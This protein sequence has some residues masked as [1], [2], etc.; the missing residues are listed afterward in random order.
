[1]KAEE[2]RAAGILTVNGGSSSLRLAVFAADG[3]ALVADARLAP[4]PPTDPAVLERFLREAG[5]GRLVAVVHRVVHGGSRLRETCWLDAGVEAEIARL[6]ALA[7]LH[8]GMALDWI[9]AARRACDAPQAA[10]F[11]TAFFVDLPP[12][13]A[14]YALPSELS[15]RFGLRRFGFHGLAHRSMLESWRGL[16]R[17]P[18]AGERVISIQLGSGCSMAAIRDG[19]PVE[20][21]MGYSPLEGLMMATRSGDVDPTVILRLVGEGGFSLEELEGI[22]NHASGLRGVSGTTADMAALLA[23][24]APQAR[25]A[26]DMFC[27]RVRK[28]LGAY[29][30]VLGGADAILF[31]GGI[32]ERAPDI[33]AR[34]LEGLAWAGIVVDPGRNAAV[35][36][37]QGGEISAPDSRVE[38]RVLPVQEARLMAREVAALLAGRAD[39]SGHRDL[40]TT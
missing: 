4:V 25:L 11:D 17:R 35:A 40:R 7:P 16:R 33:R 13:A 12:W 2:T 8:N 39:S 32:G 10:A 9:H 38:V 26:V 30:A 36:P 27:H 28:Y 3:Q 29:L 20:C 21:S 19:Q 23:D 24:E 18:P 5:V 1:M 37:P 34:V 22:L 6:K 14:R 31:G 15:E